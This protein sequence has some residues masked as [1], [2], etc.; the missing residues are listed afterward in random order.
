MTDTKK[1]DIIDDFINKVQRDPAAMKKPQ[2]IDD[3]EVVLRTIFASDD[4][5]AIEMSDKVRNVIER[6]HLTMGKRISM[7]EKTRLR[8]SK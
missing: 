3:F 4:E 6:K 5:R 8:C 1:T 2:R 7:V